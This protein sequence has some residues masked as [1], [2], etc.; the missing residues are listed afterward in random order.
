VTVANKVSSFDGEIYLDLDFVKE[1]SGYDFKERKTDYEF[2][3]KNQYD[4]SI[5]VAIPTGYKVSKM[6]ENLSV[7]SKDY[8][9]SV[10]FTQTANEIVCKKNFVFRNGVIHAADF[11]AWNDAQKKLNDI[12]KQ[13]IVLNKI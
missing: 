10:T 9:I 4:S 13:Q 6:P 12:Y 7:R 11:V 2:D 8:D 3:Y 1:Y 5:T